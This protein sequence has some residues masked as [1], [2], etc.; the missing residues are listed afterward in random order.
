MI[1]LDLQ[2]KTVTVDELLKFALS[3]SVLIRTSDGNEFILES[4][5]EFEHEV[6]SLGQSEAFMQFLAERAKKPGTVS[7]E[8]LQQKLKEQTK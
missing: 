6:A 7:L 1:T 4:V 5:D 3:D 2:Q 8:K